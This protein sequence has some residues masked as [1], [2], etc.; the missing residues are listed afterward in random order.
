[1]NLPS[2]MDFES[3]AADLDL[4]LD[5][6]I[7]IVAI[8]ITVAERDIQKMETAYDRDDAGGVASAAHSLKGSSGNLGFRNMSEI[9]RDVENGAKKNPAA[10]ERGTI[11]KIRQGLAEIASRL[12]A[13]RQP[14]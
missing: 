8:F 11:R 13:G 3:L 6:F 7:G 1:M 2:E 10:I 9:A 14:S 4:S 12:N 5:E